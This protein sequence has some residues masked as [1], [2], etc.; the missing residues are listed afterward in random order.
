MFTH[1]TSNAY[2]VVAA[3]CCSR[4]AT[5]TALFVAYRS[6]SSRLRRSAHFAQPKLGETSPHYGRIDDN[7]EDINLSAKSSVLRMGVSTSSEELFS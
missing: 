3:F 6:C 1:A 7:D 4:E 2:G 5:T